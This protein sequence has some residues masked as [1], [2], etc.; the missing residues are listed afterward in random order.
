MKLGLFL[1]LSSSAAMAA[2]VPVSMTN[3]RFTPA[4]VTINAGDT[5]TWNN[6]QGFHDTV[7]GSS[8]VPN[9]LWNSSAQF[10][11]IMQPGDSYSV[12]FNNPGTFPY[13]CSPHWPL[14]MVGSVQVIA[15]IRRRASPSL[16]R[17]TGP[18]LPPL[19]ILPS[20]QTRS[21]RMGV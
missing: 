11:R 9:G 6:Q 20:R 18:T 7:S 8:G 16:A 21:I 5:V 12:T 15:Q 14:G 17:R 10:G 1:L 13:F 2:T 19:L 4:S 3:V